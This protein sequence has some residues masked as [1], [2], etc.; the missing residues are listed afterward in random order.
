MGQIICSEIAQKITEYA[1]QFGVLDPTKE[2]AVAFYA[3]SV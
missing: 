1:N 2:A 3:T